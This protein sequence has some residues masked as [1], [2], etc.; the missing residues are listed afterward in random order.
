MSPKSSIAI[1]V[2]LGFSRMSDGEF[3]TRADKAAE[4]ARDPRLSDSPVSAADLKAA[5]D[6]FRE[7][8]TGRVKIIGP[9]ETTGQRGTTGVGGAVIT[10]ASFLCMADGITGIRAGGIQHGDTLPIRITLTMARSM[11]ITACHPIKWSPTSRQHCKRKAIIKAKWTAC[12]G[13]LHARQLQVTSA[14]RAYI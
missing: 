4:G 3:Q 13:R 1:R 7:A 6:E 11:P 12:L 10:T 5:A 9:S 2:K 8:S 14:I